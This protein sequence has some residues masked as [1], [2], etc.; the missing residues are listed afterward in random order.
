MGHHAGAPK[1]L[2][3]SVLRQASYTPGPWLL[4]DRHPELHLVLEGE[5]VILELYGSKRGRAGDLTFLILAGDRSAPRA[6]PIESGAYIFGGNWLWSDAP[7]FP[8]ASPIPIHDSPAPV[9]TC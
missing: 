4:S 1:M 2:A 8:C 7:E 5:D 6:V 3:C 9:E